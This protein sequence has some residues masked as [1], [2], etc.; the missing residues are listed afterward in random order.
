[1]ERLLHTKFEQAAGG[2]LDIP[3]GVLGEHAAECV[4]DLGVAVRPQDISRI[5]GGAEGCDPKQTVSR[6]EGIQMAME[7]VR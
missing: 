7:V 2:V 4:V 6:R 1:L 5:A 3:V